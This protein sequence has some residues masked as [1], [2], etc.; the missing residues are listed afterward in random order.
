MS[1]F[2]V[3]NY[4]FVSD[5]LR[6]M[7][8]KSSPRWLVLLIDIFLVLNSLLIT[9]LVRFNFGFSFKEQHLLTLIPLLIFLSFISF[10]ATGSYKG[11]VR[12]TGFKDAMSVVQSAVYITVAL[13]IIVFLVRQFDV[14]KML[15]MPLS[16]IGINF[17]VMVFLL[18]VSR[19]VYKGFYYYLKDHLKQPQKILIHGANTGQAVYNA[20]QTDDNN[21]Y[22]VL[23]FV[24]ERAQYKNKLIDRIR[25]YHPK[26]I[27]DSFITDKQIDAIIISKPEATPIELLDI[28]NKYLDLGVKVK[29]VPHINQWIDNKISVSQIKELNIEEL[30]NRASINIDNPEIK[31]EIQNSVVLVTGAA[32]SIGSEIALQVIGLQPKKLILL[33]QAESALYDLQQDFIRK[34]FDTD[35]FTAIVGDVRDVNRMNAYFNKFKPEIVFH[36]AA[37]KHVPLMEENPYE[38]VKVNVLGSKTVMDLAVKYETKRFVM[39][40]TDKAV[41]PTNVMGATKRAAEMYATCAQKNTDKTKFIITRFGN[42]L[43]SNGSVI[44]LF[45]KQIKQGGPLTVTHRDIVRFFMTIPEACQLVLEAGIMGKGGEIFVFDMGEPVKIYDLAKKMIQLSGLRFPEDI[46]IKITGLRPGEKLYEETL[47]QNEGDLPTHHDRVMIA[48]INE[49]PKDVILNSID[50]LKKYQELTDL[51]IVQILKTMIPE[52]ISNNSI[53]EK[54]DN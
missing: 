11:I 22:E 50:E 34:G 9:Y 30:L 16:V 44:Q 3:K 19:V 2:F 42:V 14:L 40:S 36:A 54:L 26:K 35:I 13:F 41:N 47:G 39:I 45:K 43:G 25:I 4:S 24:D 12:H 49:I 6:E 38:A 52:Y 48:Q 28:A 5:F 1:N 37:Y 32:G 23:G 15:N 18:V 51:Q 29:T 10:L 53:F 8:I 31:N 27:T 17:F 21:K 20:L 33:D 46:D 7:L